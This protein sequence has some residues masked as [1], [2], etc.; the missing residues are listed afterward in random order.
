M[1][2]PAAP[3][4]SLG[5]R[6]TTDRAKK[7]W[8]ADSRGYELAGRWHTARVLGTVAFALAAPAIT[9]WWPSST[10]LVAAAA[11]IWL[12]LARAVL[13]PAEDWERRRA[14]NAQEL[15]DTEVFELK[16]NSG[17]AGRRPA[18]ENLA[19][20]ASKYR[21]DAPSDWYADTEDLP[22]PFDVV[23]SQ[24]SSAV[25]GRSTHL[26]YAI[27]VVT[28]G[29]AVFLTGLVIGGVAHLSLT[30]YLLRLFLPS[31]PALLD[32][33]DLSRAHWSTS[34][35][36]GQIEIAADNLWTTGIHDPS[37]I[38]EADC[39]QLQDQTYRLRFNGPRVASWLYHLRRASD[40]RAMRQAVA[41]RVADYRAAQT[42]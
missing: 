14:V 20:A 17:L 41:D 25:W 2:T 6:A 15:F 31:V 33:I 42:P 3:T 28:L 32:T 35:Q 40:E 24:R 11:S 12:L 8:K 37:A 16:W 27:I 38:T 9:F 34:K 29:A 7:L 30:D 1:T 23:L 39:R 5:Q 4:S 10:D 26:A 36:K 19:K 22:R 18:E 13:S 21:G